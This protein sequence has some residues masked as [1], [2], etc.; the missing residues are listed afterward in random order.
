MSCWPRTPGYICGHLHRQSW[1]PSS[2]LKPEILSGYGHYWDGTDGFSCEL[3]KYF[4][5]AVILR[6]VSSGER[7]GCWG[8]W[9]RESRSAG[10][11]DSVD[12]IC[13]WCSIFRSTMNMLLLMI[14]Q[15]HHDIVLSMGTLKSLSLQHKSRAC[16]WPLKPIVRSK[17]NASSFPR[18]I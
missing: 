6:P 18:Y 5:Y 4:H 10:A 12:M 14:L 15:M 16:R 2:S 13:A 9:D 11:E 17:W 7:Y 8:S 1:Y 3:L